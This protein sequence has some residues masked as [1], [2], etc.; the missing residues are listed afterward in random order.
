MKKISKRQTTTQGNT[1][2]VSLP[3][4]EARAFAERCRAFRLTPEEATREAIA[5][6]MSGDVTVWNTA[7][8][9]ANART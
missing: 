2:S 3:P 6:L 8:Q 9:E 4:A 5:A 1:V 7:V